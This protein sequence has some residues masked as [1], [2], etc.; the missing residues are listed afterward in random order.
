MKDGGEGGMGTQNKEALILTDT[1][2]VKFGFR[3]QIGILH[4]RKDATRQSD[5]R[6]Q[7]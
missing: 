2:N 3:K 5:E 6:P 4:A 1:K 7:G